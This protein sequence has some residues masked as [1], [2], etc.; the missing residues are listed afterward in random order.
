[1]LVQREERAARLS[2]LA[3]HGQLFKGGFGE[4]VGLVDQALDGLGERLQL[5]HNRVLDILGQVG[6]VIKEV[7]RVVDNLPWTRGNGER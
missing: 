1:V 5:G 3:K 4:A 7:V 2:D 6:E